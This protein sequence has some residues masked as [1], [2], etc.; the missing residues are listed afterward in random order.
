MIAAKLKLLSNTKLKKLGVYIFLSGINEDR[1]NLLAEN[2]SKKI[3]FN[4]LYYNYNFDSNNDI[5]VVSASFQNYIEPCFPVNIKVFGSE[6]S[7][8]NKKVRGLKLNCYKSKKAEL[9]NQEKV[10]KID[11]LYT[12]SFSDYPLAKMAKKI[13]IIDG[14]KDYTCNNINSFKSY[15]K[16][17]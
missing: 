5:Y 10:T 13:I 14:D 17:I 4:K 7:I 3:N 12:D 16:R 15:F 1:L 6:L 9:L 8:K 11:I 2:Y